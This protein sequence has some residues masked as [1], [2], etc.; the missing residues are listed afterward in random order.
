MD[1]LVTLVGGRTDSC[2]DVVIPAGNHV[3]ACSEATEA[4]RDRGGVADMGDGARG[5]L[6]EAQE[7]LK[8]GARD[9]L[10]FVEASVARELRSRA[11]PEL[12]AWA[13]VPRRAGSVMSGG[14]GP[15]ARDAFTEPKDW[16]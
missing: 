16:A 7:G 13:C 9:C 2:P 3:V 5:A 15:Q 8:F 11:A 4:L 14:Q 12:Q 1:H 10:A 6:Q